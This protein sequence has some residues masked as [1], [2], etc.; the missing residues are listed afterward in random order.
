MIKFI[1]VFCFVSHELL[2]Q[3]PMSYSLKKGEEVEIPNT[4]RLKFNGYKTYVAKC[5]VPGKNCGAGYHPDPVT[6]PLMELNWLSECQTAPLPETC[7]LQVKV[8]KATPPEQISF[9]LVSPFEVCLQE[10]NLSN[11]HSCLLSATHNTFD[12]PAYHYSK[13][14]LIKD[15]SIRDNCVER[16][17]DK[18]GDAKI[19]DF[20]KGPMGFQ[21]TL[22]KARAANDPDVCNTLKKTERHYS[23]ADYQGQ[24]ASCRH[25]LPR[26]K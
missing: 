24:I 21:C 25:G 19:C 17:A 10:E 8:I 16:V 13:C 22:L 5:A 3:T 4:L 18:M 11:R 14:D 20:M 15:P 23:E 9:E 6:H 7:A 1:F 12:R 26:P 2:A